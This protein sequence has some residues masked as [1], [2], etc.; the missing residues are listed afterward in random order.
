LWNSTAANDPTWKPAANPT[1]TDPTDLFDAHVYDRGAM[2]LEA[3]RTVVG[4]T[5]FLAIMKEW[6]VRY[7]G[8]SQGTEDFFALAEELSGKELTAFFQDW[9]YDADK[10]A[11]PGKFTLSLA[12]TPASGTV[13]AGGAVSYTLSTQNTGKVA[14][15]GKV[16]KVDLT[17]VLDDATVDGAL[18][19][20]TTLAGNVLTWN[21]PSTATAATSTVTL[22]L[23]VNAGVAGAT[24]TAAASVPATT[25]GGTCTTCTSTLGAG[26]QPVSPAPDPTITG[27]PKV[28]QTLTA[29]TTG[30]AVDTTF[31]YVWKR[32][33]ATIP[34]ATS[35]TYPLVVDDLGAA[36]TVQVTGS[37]AGFTDVTKTSAPTAAVAGGDQV[38]TPTPTISGTARVGETLTA[39]AGSWD[40]GVT[41]TYQWLSNGAPIAGATAATYTAVAARIGMRLSVTVT[42]SR[43]GYLTVARTS[44]QTAQVVPGLLHGAKPVITGQAAVGKKLT[45]LPGAWSPGVTLRYQWFA[46]GLAISGATSPHLKVRK[47]YLGKRISVRVTGSK[48]GYET[49][50]MA[51]RKTGR[52]SG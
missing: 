38:L 24:L 28:D 5:T 43:A 23:T 11:W 39:N 33:G 13:A 29:D 31:A 35:K 47:A 1:D 42:G 3:L 36:I 32:D 30:W 9:I 7:A 49:L 14:L 41:L 19:A 45:A 26:L 37:K 8:T 52:V 27:T 2:A 4:P 34:G 6:Q 22:P 12:S 25:L 21:V 46:K 18:P 17:D 15:A 20:N 50:T 51:S 48:P 40:P 16:V 10:P 44:A